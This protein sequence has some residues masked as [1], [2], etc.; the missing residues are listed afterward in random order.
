M[1]LKKSFPRYGVGLVFLLVLT[2]VG[3]AGCGKGESSS[4]PLRVALLPVLDTLPVHVALEE[5]YFADHGVEVEIVPVSSAPERDQ[6]IAAG[7]ADG[8]LNEIVSTMFANQ[9]E[10]RVRIVRTARAAR[11]DA[12]LFRILAAENSGI[13]SVED[14]KGVDIGISEGTVIEY[15][16]DRM[17]QEEGFAAAEIAKIPVPKI[18]DRLALLGA[19]EIQ[20]AVLP[21]PLASLAVQ[22]GAR[23]IIDDSSYP[24]YGLSTFTFRADITAD[25][26]DAVA[27]FLAGV[28]QAVTAINS[29]PGKYAD[30]LIEKKLVPPPVL[31][32]YQI[33]AFPTASVPSRSQWLDALDWGEDQGLLDSRPKYEE[34]VTEDLLP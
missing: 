30:L 11:T 15:V 4:Q 21:D 5:G 10:V 26:P 22:Q 7:E 2:A 19:G 8:M 1:R 29:D 31:G 23:V 20:A 33:P 13:V 9:D 6:L 12:P 3:A 17:L 27:A 28:E 14:L 32:D 16:T 25:R 34:S 18:P 24:R